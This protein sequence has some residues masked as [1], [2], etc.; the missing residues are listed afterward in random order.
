MVVPEQALRWVCSA[1]GPGSRITGV[2]RLRLGGWHVNHAVDILDLHDRLH[3]LVLRRWARP[4]WEIQDPD[5]TVERETRVLR[6]LE[7]TPV[8][9][10]VLVSSDPSGVR[11]GVPAMLITR[12]PGHPPAGEDISGADS[13]RRLAQ[14]LAQIHRVDDTAVNL[15]PVRLYYDR[16]RAAPTA[17][18]PAS[19]VWRRA[20]SA[21]REPP[22]ASTW[23]LIHRD[24]HP[25]NTLWSAGRI[26]GVVD[27]TQA[28]SGPPALDLGHMRWN[29]VLDHGPVVA[30]RF[31]R[32]YRTATGDSPAH[33]SY[34]DLV[35]LFDLLLDQD[36]PGDLGPDDLRRLEDYATTL[37]ADLD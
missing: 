10:P 6:L 36:A 33:Q 20:I 11:C 21:V 19:G 18:M 27:W 29:L 34:W 14:A 2:R 37:L 4:G 30:D 31:L 15:A 8:P 35:S 24:F 23:A 22:P 12:L 3:R 25:E 16:A 5:Y 1:V 32:C 17:W 7:P 26:T 9:A 13:C 28:S